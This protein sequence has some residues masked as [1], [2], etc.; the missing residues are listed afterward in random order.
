[1]KIQFCITYGQLLKN[2]L[3]QDIVLLIQKQLYKTKNYLKPVR[4]SVS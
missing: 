1:M 2:S 3:K 4:K